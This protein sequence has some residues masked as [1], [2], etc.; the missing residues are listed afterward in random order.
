MNVL[1]LTRIAAGV[2]SFCASLAH[3]GVN[4]GDLD[5]SFGVGGRFSY[6]IGSGPGGSSNDQIFA[7]AVQRDGKIVVVGSSLGQAGDKDFNITRVRDDGY[8]DPSFASGGT[9]LKAFDF[10]GTNDDIARAVAIQPD[11]KILVAGEVAGSQNGSAPGP[12]TGLMRL[13]P[14]G[15][16]DTTFGPNG[17]GTSYYTP[18]DGFPLDINGVVIAEDG[19]IVVVGA[20][21]AA[22]NQDFIIEHFNAAGSNIGIRLVSFDLGGDNND[23]ATAAVIRPNGKLLVAG[24]VARGGGN[25]DCAL[26]Q[27]LPPDFIS[28]DSGFGNNG[29][30]T[31]IVAFDVGGNNADFCHA[32]ALQPDA[33]ILIAGGAARDAN[34][35]TYAAI[36]RL[37]SGGGQLDDTFAT[38]GKF[39]TYFESFADGAV[40]SARSVVVQSDG[41]IVVMGYGATNDA[42]RAPYDFAA[43]RMRANGTLDPS[44]EGSTPGSNIATTMVDFNHDDDRAFAGVLQGGRVVAMGQAKFSDGSSNEIGGIRLTSDL[45]FADSFD[46]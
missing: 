19:S 34:G 12:G 7:A 20:I 17:D 30:G 10:G 13:L 1:S 16:P 33:K 5:D 27:L 26:V 11:G 22:N 9:V 15:S 32:L 28:A 8:L 2:L 42:N 24:Y 23:V 3:A 36:A 39:T 14:D 18:N 46:Q 25:V 21:A 4:D 35:G 41:K 31:R 37:N 40:N 45:I 6:A 29:D 38:G 43:M 44:F